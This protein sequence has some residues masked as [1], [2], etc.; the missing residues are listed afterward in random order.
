MHSASEPAGVIACAS[1]KV[2]WARFLP[3]T[4]S[5]KCNVALVQLNRFHVFNIHIKNR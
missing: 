3:S 5:L 2:I 1:V 4:V